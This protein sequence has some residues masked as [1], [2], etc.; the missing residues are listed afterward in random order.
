M[1]IRIGKTPLDTKFFTN[2]GDEITG[3][4]VTELSIHV[5]ARSE[6]VSAILEMNYFETSEIEVKP[7]YLC[8]GEYIKGIVLED[9][10]IKY[11]PE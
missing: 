4:P 2:E 3:M 1:K 7:R 8:G 6:K 5:N 11:F 10:T 9:G